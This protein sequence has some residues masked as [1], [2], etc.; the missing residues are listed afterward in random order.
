MLKKSKI[1]C[2]RCG[3][4]KAEISYVKWRKQKDTWFG[5]QVAICP[6]CQKPFKWGRLVI[7]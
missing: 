5:I 7:R 4:M 1:E 3:Y 2:P 6:S